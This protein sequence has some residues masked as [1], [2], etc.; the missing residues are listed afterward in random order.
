MGRRTSFG[1]GG[2]G[3]SVSC[4]FA[5][6]SST[7]YGEFGIYCDPLRLF[8]ATG[9]AGNFRPRWDLFPDGRAFETF[10]QAQQFGKRR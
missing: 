10:S 8:L 5:L 1:L 7:A 4:L 3:S 2:K 9:P 6:F